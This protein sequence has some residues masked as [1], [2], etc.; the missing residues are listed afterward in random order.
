MNQMPS[1]CPFCGGPV[2][3]TRMYCMHCDVTV[4][5]QFQPGLEPFARLTPEQTQ[6]LLAFVRNEG[7]FNRL[8]EELNLS[9]PTL[10]NR[11][12]EVIRALGFEPGREEQ[13][14][15][16]TPQERMQVLDD[17]AQGRISAEEAQQR[18]RS[19]GG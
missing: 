2:L 10:R 13:P 1:T 3:V 16:L 7:R 11:L 9:Y 12:N 8:E 15:R 6:F 4:E 19:R 5:G 17:L 14:V 18:L